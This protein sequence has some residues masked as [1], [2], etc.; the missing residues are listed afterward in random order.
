MY[1]SEEGNAMY[2]EC[3]DKGSYFAKPLSSSIEKQP[4]GTDFDPGIE[5]SYAFALSSASDVPGLVKSQAGPCAGLE[6]EP[7]LWPG[8]GM[9]YVTA[10]NEEDGIAEVI[11]R[12]IAAE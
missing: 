9:M 3:G 11:D 1:S 10:S 12:F 5:Y 7:I 2:A 4:T 6:R 8:N